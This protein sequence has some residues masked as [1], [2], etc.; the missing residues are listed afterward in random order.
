MTHLK[1]F[2]GSAI[3]VWMGATAIVAL[4][5]TS[6]LAVN[7]VDD[8]EVRKNTAKTAATTENIHNEEKKQTKAMEDQNKAIGEAGAG[9]SSLN[10]PGW[11]GLGSQSEFYSNME[12]FGFDMCAI[13]LCQVGHNPADTTD[14]DEAREWAMKTFFSSRELSEKDMA[15]ISE[16]RRRAIAY[17]ATN[18][19]AVSNVI[20]NDLAAG[21]GSAQALEEIVSSAADFRGDIQA[22]S[23]VALANYKVAV[24]QLAVLSAILDVKAAAAISQA[25]YYHEDGADVFPNAYIDEDYL[26][27][28]KRHKVTV[29]EKGSP[30]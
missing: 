7:S 15:D 11:Q 19:L 14:I 8:R 12:K 5:S 18:G 4:T 23:A 25:G 16:V 21:G 9:M 24:Q 28:K 26:D 10:N 20:H 6:A 22:N 13:N 30:N 2:T 17:T 29:P 27:N 3:R 1:E